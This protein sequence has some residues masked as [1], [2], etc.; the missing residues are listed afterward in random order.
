MPRSGPLHYL[1][2]VTWL[3]HR[4][5]IRIELR[6]FGDRGRVAATYHLEERAP[7][8]IFRR[9]AGEVSVDVA[10]VSGRIERGIVAEFE[11]SLARTATCTQIWLDK[12]TQRSVA[13]RA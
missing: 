7:G 13:A 10:L 12:Q 8:S 5:E 11:R 3:R 9:Y 1:E 4:D 2:T 6:L